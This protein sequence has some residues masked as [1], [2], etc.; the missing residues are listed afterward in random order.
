V[1]HQSVIVE[2]EDGGAVMIG[3][4]AYT[5]DIYEAGDEADLSKWGGQYSDRDSWSD[6]LR[7]VREM[8]PSAVHFCHDTR[9]SRHL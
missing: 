2:S 5:A 9:V 1:G 4:A 3:D 7:R 8:K 6:S